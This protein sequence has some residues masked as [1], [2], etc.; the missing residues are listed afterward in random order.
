MWVFGR[1]AVGSRCGGQGRAGLGVGCGVL[2]RFA[3]LICRSGVQ[4]G[5]G[6]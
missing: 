5:T 1:A 6:R 2:D 4:A 3:A